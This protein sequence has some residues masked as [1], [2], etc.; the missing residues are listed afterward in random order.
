MSDTKFTPGPWKR[1]KYGSV[2]GANG[3]DVLFRGVAVLA[4]GSD[5]SMREAESNTD[6]LVAA[7]ELLEAL[8]NALFVLEATGGGYDYVTSSVRRAIAK[9]RGE[10]NG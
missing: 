8:E 3:S 10:I 9:A 6:L 7:P 2:I 4:S 5:E 1:D